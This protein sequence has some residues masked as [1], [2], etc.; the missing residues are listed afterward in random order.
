MRLEQKRLPEIVRMIKCWISE[1]EHA[2]NP[3][4]SR[5]DARVF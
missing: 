1:A 4:S 3:G 2:V 5:F